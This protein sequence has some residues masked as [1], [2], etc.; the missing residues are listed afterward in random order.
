MTATAIWQLDRV[1][2]D[3]RATAEAA[4]QAS[5]MSLSQWLGRVIAETCA[6]EGVVLA[7]APR[8]VPPAP[9]AVYD[10]APPSSAFAPRP[11]AP[12]MPP[13]APVHL[14]PVPQP[15]I[16]VV[17]P[18]Q[19]APAGGQM[20]LPFDATTLMLPPSALEPGPVGA[21]GEESDASEALVAAIARE[22]MRKPILVRR[23]PGADGRY[24]IIA[25][26]RR[27]R[28]AKRLGLNQIAVVV[29]NFGDPEAILASLAENLGEGDL[30]PLD[31]AKSYLRLLTEFSL[32]PRDV[33]AATG[34]DMPHIVRTL[35]L[36]GLPPK[37]R[38][39]ISNGRI[40]RG[41]AYTLLDQ[42][43]P[44]RAAAQMVSDQS[45]VDE[46]LRRIA[47]IAPWVRP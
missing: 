18:P 24:E 28:A 26:R 7:A 4:A 15:A 33:S 45:S 17:S 8:T 42:P 5:G 36:L 2:P 16:R 39:M 3:A 35:R 32:D 23:K 13:Q 6:A 47:A 12:A 25:G 14:R 46:A 19:L 11:V 10:Q 38:E 44:E 40:T 31:E 30:S 37:V 1:S 22:G 34:R 43:D 9:R 21:R 29:T 41:N 27:W 20:V